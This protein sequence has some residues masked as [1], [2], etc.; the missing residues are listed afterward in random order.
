MTFDQAKKLTNGTPVIYRGSFGGEEPTECKWLGIEY[1]PNG[2]IVGTC[3]DVWGCERWGYF[4]Q[5]D[6]FPDFAF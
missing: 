5:F 6:L 3:I 2:N 1:H 4:H